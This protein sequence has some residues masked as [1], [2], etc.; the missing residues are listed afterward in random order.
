[1]H[2]LM[3][4]TMGDTHNGI[5]FCFTGAFTNSVGFRLTFH[6]SSVLFRHPVISI[7]DAQ[8]KSLSCKLDWFDPPR[9]C[10]IPVVVLSTPIYRRKLRH[11]E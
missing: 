3:K 11:Q 4:T 9:R 2:Y 7:D 1:M 8:H 5:L 6:K 10:P